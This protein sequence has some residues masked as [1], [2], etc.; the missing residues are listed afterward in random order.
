M[1][2]LFAYFPDDHDDEYA[3]DDNVVMSMRVTCLGRKGRDEGCRPSLKAL[4][5]AETSRRSLKLLIFTESSRAR[6]LKAMLLR[7]KVIALK[8]RRTTD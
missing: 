5:Q 8:G 3:D 4:S 1:I 7:A 2:D 6:T